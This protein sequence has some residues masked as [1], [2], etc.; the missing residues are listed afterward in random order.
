MLHCVAK[1]L[2]GGKLM[3]KSIRMIY[4]SHDEKVNSEKV[5][6]FMF[7]CTIFLN[8]VFLFSVGRDSSK[9]HLQSTQNKPRKR[10]INGRI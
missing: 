4:V 1:V 7:Y 9:S 6:V 8:V 10:E 2:Q 3:R 5:A